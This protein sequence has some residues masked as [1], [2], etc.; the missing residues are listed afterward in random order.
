MQDRKKQV[1]SDELLAITEPF[2]VKIKEIEQ[3]L[4]SD[5]L[6]NQGLFLMATALFEDTIREL[7]KNILL[8]FPDKLDRKTCTISRKQIAE[9]AEKGHSVIIDNELYKMFHFGVKEQL[10][11]LLRV[12]FNKSKFNKDQKVPKRPIDEKEAESIKKISE[13]FLFRNVL[14]HNAGKPNQTLANIKYFK[15][16]FQYEIDFNNNLVKTFIKEY[17]L[18]V[19]KVNEDIHLTFRSFKN[20]STIDKTRILWNQCFSSSILN[21]D[22]FWEIDTEKDLIV[23]VKYPKVESQISCS[24]QILLSIWR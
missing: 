1:Y 7:L 3:K 23:R 10:E 5:Q 24:E 15:L 9:I 8:T 14:I 19:L 2:L 17:K 6:I 4:S 11:E 16:K 20:A 22:D 18:F 12:L 21:F 13:I